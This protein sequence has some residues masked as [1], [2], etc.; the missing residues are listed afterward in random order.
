MYPSCKQGY[1]TNYLKLATQMYEFWTFL[2]VVQICGL[3][4]ALEHNMGTKYI[5]SG[6]LGGGI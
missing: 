2:A 4:I 3:S 5:R 1:L 6:K